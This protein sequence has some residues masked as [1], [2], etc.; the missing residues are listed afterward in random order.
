MSTTEKGAKPDASEVLPAKR[1]ERPIGQDLAL[2]D[3][4]MFPDLLNQDPREVQARFAS[5]FSRAKTIEDLFNVLSGTV[6]RDMVGRRLELRSVKWAPY[7]SDDGVIPLGIAE[8]ADLDSGE[9]VEFATTSMMLTLFLRQ[10]E[11]V[12]AYPFEA[13]ITSKRTRGGRD[14]LNLEPA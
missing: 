2:Y 8:A 9:V 13:R 14:A 5:R 12:N 1:G 3:R 10:A 11:L 6:S 7:E 4:G